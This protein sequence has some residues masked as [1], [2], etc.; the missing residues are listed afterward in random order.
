[1]LSRIFFD[2]RIYLPQFCNI[3]PLSRQNL[4][5]RIYHKYLLLKMSS[6]IAFE[7]AGKREGLQVWRIEN[8]ALN[9]IPQ[10]Q[11]G[12]FY[13]GDCY[14]VLSSKK[15]GSGKPH[16]T[17]GLRLNFRSRSTL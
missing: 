8:F 9:H 13:N 10:S 15:S 6:E 3:L 12:N 1:M 2:A 11:F 16:F 7:T 17:S 14:L 5:V 4:S